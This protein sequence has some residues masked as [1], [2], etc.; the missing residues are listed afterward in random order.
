MSYKALLKLTLSFFFLLWQEAFAAD[1][2]GVF[3][4]ERASVEKRAVVINEWQKTVISIRP[5]YT[6]LTNEGNVL[7]GVEGQLSVRHAFQSQWAV[8]ASFGQSFDS[9]SFSSLY[10]EMGV[11]ATYAWSGSIQR[12]QQRTQLSE[13][14]VLSAAEYNQGGLFTS[15]FVKQ[16]FFS[17]S[18]NVIPLTGLGVAAF[19]QFSS[20][21]K[22]NFHFGVAYDYIANG[23]FTLSPLKFFLGM[24]FWL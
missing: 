16:Y 2:L 22:L 24:D 20:T 10:S 21:S 8:S 19:Y 18:D 12:L 13:F 14:N 15:V 4:E 3:E 17:G 23:E 11:G 6:T 7:N 1:L 9:G 5:G